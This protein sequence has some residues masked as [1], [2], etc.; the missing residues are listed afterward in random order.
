MRRFAQHDNI[1]HFMFLSPLGERN[2]NLKSQSSFLSSVFR[3]LP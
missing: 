2:M 1:P 3:I